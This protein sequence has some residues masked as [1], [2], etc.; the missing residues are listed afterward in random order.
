MTD[1]NGDIPVIS[2]EE[3]EE[4][5]PKRQ[6]AHQLPTNRLSVETALNLLRA[7]AAE[8]H[9]GTQLVAVPRVAKLADVHA[10][11]P[12]LLN[13][14][15]VDAGLLERDGKKYRP[16]REVLDY[17]AAFNFE[18]STAARKLIPAIQRSW[19]WTALRPRLAMRPIDREEAIAALAEAT[20]AAKE[21]RP[22]LD[23]LIEFLS[24]CEFL[25]PGEGGRF[26][27]P[28]SVDP[29][30]PAV[31]KPLTDVN[32]NKNPADSGGGD[33]AWAELLLKK[34]PDFD[35]AWDVELKKSWFAAFDDLM[36]KGAPK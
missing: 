6:L 16:V 18:P 22:R 9:D 2:G 11:T 4:R 29:A 1:K 34:F 5:V 20:R 8:S 25:T 28:G 3:K 15:F 21:D 32:R 19:I 36:K 14:F 33:K 10:S 23:V 13:S 12:S 35:P 27:G 7:Y 26:Q 31:E 24:G 17:Q 30:P